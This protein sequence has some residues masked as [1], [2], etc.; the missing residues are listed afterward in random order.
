MKTKL[1]KL[2]WNCQPKDFKKLLLFT[3]ISSSIIFSFGGFG[4][5]EVPEG[6]FLWFVLVMLIFV[7]MAFLVGFTVHYLIDKYISER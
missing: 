6:K 7:I 2:I 1:I 5:I 3:I 4:I